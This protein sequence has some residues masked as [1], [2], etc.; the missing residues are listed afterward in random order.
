MLLLALY[1]DAQ[2]K[3]YEEVAEVWP[4]GNPTSGAV[5]VGSVN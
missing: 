5:S 2:R 3:L 4:I 1:P